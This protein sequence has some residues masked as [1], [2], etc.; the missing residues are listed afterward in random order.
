MAKILLVGADESLKE[1]YQTILSA[2][3]FDTVLESTAKD[4]IDRLSD[5]F[6]P[7]CVIFLPR[8]ETLWFIIKVR[9]VTRVKISSVPIL[10]VAEQSSGESLSEYIETGATKVISKFP[11]SGDKLVKELRSILNIP[12]M[13]P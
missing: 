1:M 2:N 10:A 9:Q 3:G 7:A 6:F 13:A 8:E 4:G 12:R 5:E 11:T